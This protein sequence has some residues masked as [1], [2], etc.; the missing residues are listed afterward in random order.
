MN[1]CSLNEYDSLKNVFSS[2]SHKKRIIINSKI[3]RYLSIPYS[4]FPRNDGLLSEHFKTFECCVTVKPV[5]IDH[6]YNKILP[7]GAHLG[8]QVSH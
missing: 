7:S 8:G 4:K 3:I 1:K 5:C 6:L 2:L